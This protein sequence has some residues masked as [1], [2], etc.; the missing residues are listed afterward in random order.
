M[1]INNVNCDRKQLTIPT[2]KAIIETSK[3]NMVTTMNLQ[4][5][6][7]QFLQ[8]QVSLDEFEIDTESLQQIENY[9]D[10]REFWL[11]RND[12]GEMDCEILDPQEIE[13]P[14]VP[15]EGLYTL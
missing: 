8:F 15:W 13:N 14:I 2:K 9:Y 7:E 5:S 4:Q 12:R 10:E 1:I 11:D 6:H 3:T